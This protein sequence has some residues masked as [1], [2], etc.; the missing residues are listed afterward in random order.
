MTN[1]AA[2]T[3]ADLD[4][5]AQILAGCSEQRPCVWTTDGGDTRREGVMR[6]LRRHDAD[7][8]IRDYEVQISGVFEVFLDIK[9]VAE[10]IRA[11]NFF[12]R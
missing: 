7:M 3:I 10:L 2:F 1:P 11:R 6:P 8:D 5:Y 12:I 4:T 9:T